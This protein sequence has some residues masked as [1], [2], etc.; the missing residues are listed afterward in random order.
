MFI[1][2]EANAA[3]AYFVWEKT[4]IDV[5]LN[6]S[7]ENYKDKYELSFYVN[8]SKSKDYYVEKEVNCSTFSTVLTNKIGKYTVYY[9]AV[10]EKILYL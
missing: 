7:L 8:G 5:P 2:Y 6:S 10:S 4:Q 3:D 1:S 9:K